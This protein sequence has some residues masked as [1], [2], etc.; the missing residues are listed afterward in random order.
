MYATY[1]IWNKHMVKFLRNREE[2][3]G[4]ALQS[5]LWVV[6]FGVGMRGLISEIEGRDYMSYIL[7]GILALSVLGGAVGG[8]M[9]MLD[10]RLRG[11]LK[12][13]LAAPIPRL[14]ILLGSATSTAT[15]ALF[16]AVL[17]LVVGILMGARLALNPAGWLVSLILLGLFALGFSGIALAVAAVSRSIAGYHG[18]IFL[19]NLPLLFASNALYPLAVLPGWMQAIV[20]L[21]PTTYLI[22]AIR[23]LAFGTT[24]TLP[25]T[26]SIA[27]VTL[28]AILGTW[29]AL[30]MFQRTIRS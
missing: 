18:M 4:L 6:L 24:A 9:V 15:K 10:E 13:Y 5:V 23:T 21:N 26:L 1:V 19:F 2:L 28:F 3:L 16:Q 29:L 17:M 7:P 22:D 8:G 25:L 30:S 27:V 20:L 11:I 14:S 12:E